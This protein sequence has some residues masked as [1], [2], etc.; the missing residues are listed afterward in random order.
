MRHYVLSLCGEVDRF[1]A[2]RT[3]VTSVKLFTGC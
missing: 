2:V 3:L 1:V